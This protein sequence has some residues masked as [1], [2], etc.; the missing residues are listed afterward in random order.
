MKSG[1]IGAAHNVAFASRLRGALLSSS[2]SGCDVDTSVDE[3]S[4][5]WEGERSEEGC[6]PEV[7]FPAG[8]SQVRY[9]ATSTYLSLPNRLVLRDMSEQIS[10]DPES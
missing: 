3:M 5:V 4:V 9:M 2:T 1:R 8:S 6:L 7:Q 10:M